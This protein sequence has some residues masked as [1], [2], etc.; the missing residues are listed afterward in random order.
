MD[1]TATTATEISAGDAVIWT[2][3]VASTVALNDG[4]AGVRLIEVPGP[5]GSTPVQLTVPGD[6]T[7][8]AYDATD[9]TEDQAARGTLTV[10]DDPRPTDQRGMALP[11]RGATDY[12]CDVGAV[13]YQ[14]W[15]V[16]TPLLRPP[17]AVGTQPPTWSINDAQ[18]QGYD[19]WS[20]A[21]S[22]DIPIA[23][24]P[25]LN[26]GK[27]EPDEWAAAAWDSDPRPSVIKNLVQYGTVEWP[28]APQ[29][30]VAGAPVSLGHDKITDG[31]TPSG[32]RGFDNR[33]PDDTLVVLSSN[34]FTRTLGSGVTYTVVRWGKGTSSNALATAQVIRTYD[35]K[36]PGILDLADRSPCVIGSELIYPA[37]DG[38]PGHEDP[39]GK[40]GMILAGTAFD[41]VQTAAELQQV[42]NTTDNLIEPAHVR[43]T[44]T[45]P[46]LPVLAEAPTLAYAGAD[47]V[48]GGHDLEV[49]WYRPDD[50]KVAWPVKTAGYRCDW[51]AN[52]PNIVIASELGSEIDG[53]EPLVTTRYVDTTIYHQVNENWPGYSPNYEHAL[54][55]PS[56]TGLS[57]PALYALRTDLADRDTGPGTAAYALLKYRDALQAN[58]IQM[59]AYKVLLTREATSIGITPDAI[60]PGT[61]EPMSGA[62]APADVAQLDVAG[63]AAEYAVTPDASAATAGV[64]TFRISD[65][66]LASNGTSTVPLQVSGATGL[67]SMALIVTYPTDKLA[68]VRCAPNQ[69][70]VAEKPYQ[71][72]LSAVD[73][74]QNVPAG[75]VVHLSASV[76]AGTGLRY[77]WKFGDE[78]DPAAP[79]QYDAA[80]V[81][82]VYATSGSKTV[83]VIVSNAL[84]PDDEVTLTT[85]VTVAPAESTAAPGPDP[86]DKNVTASGCRFDPAEPGKL[87]LDLRALNKHGLTGVAKLADLTF[88][89]PVGYACEP[90]LAEPDKCDA[91]VGLSTASLLGPDYS[92]LDF[93][94]TAGNPVYAPT[95]VRNLLDIQPCAET[96]AADDPVTHKKPAPFWKDWK[97]M[98]WARAAGN[99]S[100]SYF[101]PLQPGFYLDNAFVTGHGLPANE[102]DRVG[103]C[104]PWLDALPD[105]DYPAGTA[106]IS[107]VL[108]DGETTKEV[109]VYP[110]SYTV[111]WPKLPALLDVGETVYQ[112]G[113]GRRFRRGVAG[114]GLPRLRRPGQ[115][116]VEQ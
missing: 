55:A 35:P 59:R 76:E 9:F 4:Q 77:L 12:K 51:P 41:G 69:N 75:Q 44:R 1:L 82:H 104:V 103:L 17:S 81:S 22:L 108:P 47:P 16:G 88:N 37:F 61:I 58:R 113:E 13:E 85:T 53:Q 5:S 38:L 32:A 57:S 36:T 28:D 70:L 91:T 29:V 98:L 40:S 94:I 78:E 2:N 109:K 65:G 68:P 67:R 107:Y 114:C 19:M 3:D 66:R 30:H 46:I 50:R 7:Y 89:R 26:D 20:G 64:L 84:F 99:M 83:T 79:G 15:V 71:S 101:Y 43:D 31:F 106:T 49:A 45:G 25:L 102:A 73:A 24:T 93:G 86:W 87:R 18:V 96:V 80:R 100:M 27:L 90:T 115:G 42:R 48:S 60:F 11:Q 52:P 112:R 34:T 33:V 111:S 8:R 110:T 23:P 116:R 97:G 62:A 10:R 105:A 74:E 21:N 72:D 39:E 56:N 6:Y 54:L 95:P 14:P 92:R 63:A